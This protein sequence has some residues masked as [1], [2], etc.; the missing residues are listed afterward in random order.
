MSSSDK[1]KLRKEQNAAN[2]TARQ[3]KEQKEAKKLKIYTIAFA[4]IMALVVVTVLGVLIGRAV[5]HSGVLDRNTHALTVGNHE[6]SSAELNYFYK[7]SINQSI[8]YWYSMYGNNLTIY[9][10]MMGGPDLTKS[11]GSQ[12]YDA[13]TKQS[14]GDYFVEQAVTSAKSTFALYDLAV[15]DG[16]KLTEEEQKSLDTTFADLEKGATTNKV[17]VTEYLKATYGYGSTEESFREYS[18]VCAL[19][20]SYYAAHYDSLKYEDD[21]LRE[22][23]KDK[24]K[25]YSAYSYVSFP[26]SYTDFL[27]AKEKDADGKEIPH[28][29]EQLAAARAAVEEA[30]KKIAEDTSINSK[31][32][33]DKALQ[34]LEVYK[35]KTS[36]S[37]EYT[38]TLYGSVN[39]TIREWVTADERKEGDMTYI[40]VTSTTKDEDGKETTVTNGYYVV[41]FSGSTDNKYPLADVRHLLI[42]FEGGSTDSSGNKT[43]TDAEKK[44]AKDEAESLYEEWKKGDATEESFA[45]LAKKYTEDDSSKE[46]GGLYEDIYPKQMDTNFNDWCFE[47]GR[48]A[49]DTGVIETSYGYHVMY[50]VGDADLT[51]RDFMLTNDLRNEEMSK[52][53]EDIQKNISVTE[54]NL[55]R[56]NRDIVPLSY[57]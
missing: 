55:S 10:P 38:D 29:D 53:Y 46:N 22:Y 31:L 30:A 35:E 32:R 49:G 13:E 54:H 42:K 47:E 39:E 48:K 40:P 3:Q 34:S 8:N 5:D 18:E 33:L 43:Y 27:P 57:N 15:Q 21:D 2:L 14:W 4:V 20:N 17:S 41:L 44:K 7:D 23:E 1:K 26:M 6:L 16:H 36:F 52:W 50:Y 9:L 45:E 51:Y 28:T 24:F 25:D 12:V 37:T 11:L 56:I 19:A